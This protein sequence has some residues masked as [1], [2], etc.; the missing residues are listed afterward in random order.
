MNRDEKI[1]KLKLDVIF[2]R[3]FDTEQNEKVIRW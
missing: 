3:M 1:V 2:K